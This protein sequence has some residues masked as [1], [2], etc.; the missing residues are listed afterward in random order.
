[1]KSPDKVVSSIGLLSI[2]SLL[3]FTTAEAT[4]TFV[5][6]GDFQDW[7]SLVVANGQAIFT[8]HSTGG[9]PGAY[10]EIAT[11]NTE[12][13]PVE[14]WALTYKPDYVWYPATDGPICQVGMVIDEKE[15]DSAGGGQNVKLLVVQGAK[16]YGAT[17]DPWNVGTGTGTTWETI[18]IGSAPASNFFEAIDSTGA[19]FDPTSKPDFSASGD[20]I[21]FGFMLG[22]RYVFNFRV[23]AFDN[24]RIWIE[25]GP[26]STEPTTWSRIKSMYGTER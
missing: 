18:D 4:P 14:V 20:P 6:D 26:S 23:H 12:Y 25:T 10:L 8:R 5:E 13:E 7:V 3:I 1:M 17:L 9:N 22:N 16:Y 21:Q 11:R 15:I 24:W 2:L 19:A